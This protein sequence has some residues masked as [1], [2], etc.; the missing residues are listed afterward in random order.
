[1]IQWTNLTEIDELSRKVI[2]AFQRDVW[3]LMENS[4]HLVKKDSACP[5]T[6]DLLESNL[7]RYD[8]PNCPLGKTN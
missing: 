5:K 3:V 2:D 1:M 7:Q 8:S 4:P 6:P